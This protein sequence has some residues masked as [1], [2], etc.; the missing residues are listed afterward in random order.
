MQITIHNG[1]SRIRLTKTE[2]KKLSDSL[3]IL[4]GIEKFEPHH[5]A[6]DELAMVCKQI[7]DEGVFTPSLETDDDK[8]VA[9]PAK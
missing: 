1:S 3:E 4:R 5:T 2:R 8:P 6:A 9:G 7:D